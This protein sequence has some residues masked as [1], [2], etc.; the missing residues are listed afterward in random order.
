[1]VHF[2][3]SIMFGYELKLDAFCSVRSSR[4]SL[5]EST[6]S[7]DENGVSEANHNHTTPRWANPR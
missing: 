6:G 7:E 3:S 5:D 2:E 4:Q 1:M